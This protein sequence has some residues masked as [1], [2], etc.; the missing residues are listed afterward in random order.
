MH[1]ILI[2]KHVRVFFSRAGVEKMVSGADARLD[3]MKTCFWWF[4]QFFVTA[5]FLKHSDRHDNKMLTF[6]E[7]SDK[8]KWI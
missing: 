7:K 4:K 2:Q 3:W 8:R 5:F 6:P 1:E